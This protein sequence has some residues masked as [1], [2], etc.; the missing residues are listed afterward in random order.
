MVKME[1]YILKM[2]L[3]MDIYQKDGHLNKLNNV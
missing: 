1:K 2:T 3:E